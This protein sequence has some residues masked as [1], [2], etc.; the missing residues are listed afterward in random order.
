MQEPPVHF[1]NLEY[2]F[3][4]LYEAIFGV[5]GTG[6]GGVDRGGCGGIDK[7]G[8]GGFFSTFFGSLTDTA[9]VLWSII[10]IL[11]FFLSLF[12]GALLIYSLLQLRRVR[13]IEE[14]YYGTLLVKKDEH[15]EGDPRWQHIEALMANNTS[16]DF[17]QAIVEADIMLDDMLTKQGYD[18]ASVGDKL[19]RA[20][21]SDF[22]T[23]DDA[24]EA[25]KVRNKI[26]HE[27]SAFVLTEREAH[28]AIERYRRVFS[29]FYL[30]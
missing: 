3:R 8:S 25:H 1:L 12:L 29:E 9:L 4:V 13:K 22:L 26:A 15:A 2:F 23:L 27:G 18:G 6:S 20:E 19:K 14:A 10:S 5:R 7:T 11:G 28:L 21:R 24:W 16:S 30:L 17:R